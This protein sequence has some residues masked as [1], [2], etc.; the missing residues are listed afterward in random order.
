MWQ[1][2]L[3]VLFPQQHQV[4]SAQRLFCCS[5]H[6]AVRGYS[7]CLEFVDDVLFAHT[8]FFVCVCAEASS[9]TTPVS[10][11]LSS[12]KCSG[13]WFHDRPRFCAVLFSICQQFVLDS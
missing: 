5:L 6:L 1:W 3:C 11:H 9:H 7:L 13:K 10:S 4:P 8:E 12:S 2:H